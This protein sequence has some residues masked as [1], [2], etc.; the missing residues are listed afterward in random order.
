MAKNNYKAEMYDITTLLCM[1][2]IRKHM[3]LV[4][5]LDPTISEESDDESSRCS[6]YDVE[7]ESKRKKNMILPA[8]K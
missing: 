8:V 7:N 5:V 4:D 6:V 2:C 3:D 1:T